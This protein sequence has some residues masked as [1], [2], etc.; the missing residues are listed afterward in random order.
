[1]HRKTRS[2]TSNRCGF[3]VLCSGFQ[4]LFLDAPC[5]LNVG[6]PNPEN[7]LDHAPAGLYT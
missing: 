3:R 2:Y 6:A 4:K 5:V 7:F 1:M